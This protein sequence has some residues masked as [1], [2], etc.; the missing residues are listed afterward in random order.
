[1]MKSTEEQFAL[2]RKGSSRER[3]FFSHLAR[4]TVAGVKL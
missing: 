4:C 2:G 3:F 1:M